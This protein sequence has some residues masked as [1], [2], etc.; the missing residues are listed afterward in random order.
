MEVCVISSELFIL[1]FM[2]TNEFRKFAHQFAD[3]M[4][5]YYEQV[6][7]Y[8]VKSQVHPKDIFT[9]L[10]DTPPL[11]SES[12]EDIFSDFERI[13]LPGITHWQSPTYFAYFPANTSYPSILAEMLTAALGTQA[14]IWDTSPAAA[15]LEEQVMHWLRDMMELPMHWEGVIQPTASDA[16]LC[17]LLTAREVVTNYQINESGYSGKEGFRVYCSTQTHSS[18]EKAAKIAGIGKNNVV[19]VAVD[20]HFAMDA[21]ALD[22][23]IQEDIQSGYTPL[24]VIAALGTTSSTAIDPIEAMGH[25]CQKYGVWFHIDAAFAGTALILPECR[26]MNSGAELADSFVF[27]P[28]KWMFTNFDCSAYFV[29]ESSSLVRTFE[30]LPEYLKTQH[31]REVND[32]RDWGIP[33]GRRFRALKLWFVIRHFGLEGLQEKLR[34]HIALAQELKRLIDTHPDFQLLAPVPL[35]TLCFRYQP[36]GYS[37][38]QINALNQQLLEQ[39]NAS[40]KMYL[41]H[42]KLNGKYTIRLVIGQTNVER[43]HVTSAWEHIVTLSHSITSLDSVSQS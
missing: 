39:L 25:I 30:I 22:K 10:N 15:E 29:K 42:T 17:A 18:I 36:E 31:Q 40:G 34:Y 4:A 16:T 23:A 35:N 5:D 38:E 3:W 11:K 43:H 2:N 19:K 13:I 41:T 9:Q 20:E 33:L 37:E 7:N 21:K 24:C 32:Y 14:M 12:M 6:E 26:W 28:H 27:N 1:A 8:P